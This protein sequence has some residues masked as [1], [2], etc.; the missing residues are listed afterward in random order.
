MMKVAISSDKGTKDAMVDQRFGRCKYF[1]VVDTEKDGSWDA[2]ENQGAIQGHGAG[3]RAA[4][5][6]GE[7]GAKAVITG[8]VGPNAE[9]VL[10]GLGISTYHASGPLQDAVEKFKEGELNG[11]SEIEEEESKPIGSDERI[12]FPLL[13]D[14]GLDSRIS[15]HFGH[16]P[17]FGVYDIGAKKFR[18]VPN[19]LDHTD[20]D[21]SPVDQIIETVNPTTVYAEGIGARALALFSQKGISIKTGPYRRVREVIDNLDKL[22]EQTT[23]CGH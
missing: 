6:V 12:F 1:V 10:S 3:I 7:I 13:D 9:R 21:K 8:D 16:A 15:P 14:K 11:I 5:Q 17:V 4:Q 23:D 2:H 20:P 18:T 19:D 22:E